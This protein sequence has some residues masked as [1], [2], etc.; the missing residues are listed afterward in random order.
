MPLELVLLATVKSVMDMPPSNTEGDAILNVLIRGAS[1]DFEELSGRGV[2]LIERT[3]Y[4]D[5]EA[6]TDHLLLKGFPVANSPA[7]KIYQDVDRVFGA[8]TEVDSSYYFLDEERGIVDLFQQY[9]VAP[10]T[11]KVVYTGGMA[12]M[13]SPS[14]GSEFWNLYPDVAEA[15]ILEVIEQYKRKDTLGA[16]MVK[17]M[18]DS[19]T[20]NKPKQRSPL[21]MA[22]VRSYQRGML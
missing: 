20:I 13:E 8:T 19:V 6:K 4:F 5:V 16:G 10:K 12:K 3:E 22:M 18:N 14:I 1:K 9:P 21:F 2:D 11:I 7:I 15:V 17:I